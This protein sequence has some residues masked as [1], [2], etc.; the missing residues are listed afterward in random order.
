MRAT[1]VSATT[2]PPTS[3]T[4][5]SS[6]PARTS[7]RSV[8][9]TSIR[10]ATS[11]GAVPARGRPSTVRAP[12]VTAASASAGVRCPAVMSSEVVSNGSA[13]PAGLNGSRRLSAPAA[14]GMPASRMRRTAVSPR[15]AA[16]VAS[17]PCRYRLVIGRVTIPSPARATR[18]STGSSRRGGSTPSRTQWLAVTRPASP[19]AS[20]CSARS[21]MSRRPSAGSAVCS[22]ACRSTGR[23]WRSATSSIRLTSRCG[24]G[25]R[26]GQ[27]PTTSIPR[28]TASATTA[29][30][31]SWPAS[32][33]TC[34]VIRPRSCSRSAT[35]A[36]TPR[37]GSPSISRSTC[38]RTVVMPCAR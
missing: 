24:S 25:A 36:S 2:R 6:A 3:T 16:W 14:S 38:V 20:T 29:S 10:S 5:A 13:R 18:S 37:N 12:S 7:P 34:S 33:H 1:R 28:A 26:C 19:R 17:R 30:P 15:G 27:P 35:S 21:S 31:D 8:S 9:G 23:P 11:P 22:S 32:R 4:R